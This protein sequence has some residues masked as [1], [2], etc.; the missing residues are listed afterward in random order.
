[1]KDSAPVTN[2]GEGVT[3]N[4]AM[5][6]LNNYKVIKRSKYR[7]EGVLDGLAQGTGIAKRTFIIESFAGLAKSLNDGVVRP[8]HPP[9][10]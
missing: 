2:G 8:D 1:M 10:E 6:R 3:N 4:D 5:S 9:G 7:G